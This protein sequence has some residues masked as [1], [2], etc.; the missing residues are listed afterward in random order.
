MA[1]IHER[2]PRLKIVH[3]TAPLVHVQS[4]PKALVKRLIGQTPDHYD[5]NFARERYNTLMRQAYAG[6]EPVFDIAA[7]ESS[8]PGERREAFHFRGRDLYELRA[9][10][11]T[12]DAHLNAAAER[13]VA[14]ELLAFL[15]RVAASDGEQ[16]L[17][18]A[19]Y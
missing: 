17:S 16:L 19:R 9:E 7:L 4:G 10:Y 18:S 2:F 5:D 15:Q 11:T 14:A 3:V 13:R 1:R 8:R 6:R 12:D